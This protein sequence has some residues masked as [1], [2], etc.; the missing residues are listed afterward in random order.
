[1]SQGDKIMATSKSQRIGIWVIAVTMLVGTLGSF[2]VYAMSVNG[3]STATN[4]DTAKNAELLKQ[5]QEQQKAAAIESAAKA[6]PFGG[7]SAEAFDAASVTELKVETLVEGTGDALK[8]DSS[9]KAS[10]FGWLSDGKIF[11]SSKK[12]DTDDTPITLSLSGVIP[13]WTKGLTGVKVGSVVKLTIPAA[14]AYGSQESGIIPKDSPLVFIV[15]VHSI[16]ASAAK[17]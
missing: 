4:P 17:S 10:Y 12:K 13:G 7:Y 14:Q 2:V 11:D 5:Y 16:E 1:M 9:L 3:D 6:E 15:Q 8:A